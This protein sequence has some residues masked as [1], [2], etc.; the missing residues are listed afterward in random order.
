[1]F[2]LQLSTAEAMKP[3][4]VSFFIFITVI[5]YSGEDLPRSIIPSCVGVLSDQSS[6]FDDG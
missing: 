2:H 4:L 5:G 3:E 1:M 6:S